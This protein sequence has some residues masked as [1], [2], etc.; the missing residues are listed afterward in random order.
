[1]IHNLFIDFETF[2]D[3]KDKYDLRKLS[4]LEY[5]HD[6]RFKAFGLGYAFND[7]PVTWVSGKDIKGFLVEIPWPHVAVVGHNIKF[8]GF[9]LTQKYGVQPS[10]WIDTMGMARAVLG[11]TV[12]SYSLASLAAHYKLESKGVL[13]TNGLHDLSAEQT[14]QLAEYCKH[15][16]NLCREIYNRLKVKFPTSQY[17]PLHQTVRMF[18]NPKLELNT[19]L[20]ERTS[21]R[22]KIRKEN[23]F[24]ELGIEKA[25]FAS[26]QKFT[27]LLN[28]HEYDV[29]M[30][31]SPRIPEK[32]IPALALGD[33]GFLDMLESGDPFLKSLCEARVAAKSVLLE[34]RSGRLAK[35]GKAGKWSFDVQFSGATQTH[36]YSGGN[37]AGGNPQNFTRGSALREAVIAPEGKYL[38]V[39]DFS[40]IELRLAAYLSR[41]EKLIRMIENN[42]DVYCHYASVFFKRDI[43]KAD[44]MERRFGKTVILAAGYGMGANKFQ[45]TVRLQ[46]GQKIDLAT[47]REAVNLYRSMYPSIP[48]LWEQLDRFIPFL[49]SDQ[50][51]SVGSLPLRYERETILLPSGLPM[52][53]PNLRRHEG[54]WVYD[55]WT[56]KGV[57]EPTKLYGGKLLENICQALAGELCKEA[58]RG[59]GDDVVGQNHDEILV[60]T[61]DPKSY[62]KKL[63]AAMTTSPTWMPSIKLGVEVGVGKTWNEAK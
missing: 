15:D 61:C 49:A 4:T 51:G 42:E 54:E 10:Q 50:K 47:S 44:E 1:M 20:L 11:K 22:E 59:L 56:K 19:E 31:P 23:L 55:Q 8:D 58:M 52:Y 34:T 18:V 63:S 45:K 48:S 17:T 62:S 35:L 40:N 2:Y 28:K 26:N 21:E 32:S 16:V 7:G 60:L 14:Y 29:P 6:P 46:T 39:G 5:V 13:S 53:Y 25:V 36:R 43:T 38:V 12:E 57:K 3:T 33:T 9:I 37:N 24:K 30:K 41:E 27:A